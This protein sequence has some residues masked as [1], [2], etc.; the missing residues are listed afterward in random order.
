MKVRI[1]E[2]SVGHGP[3]LER[4]AV[5]NKWEVVR[6]NSYDVLITFISEKSTANGFIIAEAIHTDRY[7]LALVPDGE[8]LD[9]LGIDPQKKLIS[10]KSFNEGSLVRLVQ[11]YLDLRRRGN[12]KRF[13][14][15]IPREQVE[16]LE[17]V[18]NNR[19]KSK[20]NFVRQ[21]ISEQLDKDEDYSKQENNE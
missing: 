12:L 3:L 14:F 11:E 17:W 5:E 4:M 16:Y 10:V 7:V 15:V 20:S 13:N 18:T 6:D 8:S 9:S 1:F 2:E 21:L 19:G